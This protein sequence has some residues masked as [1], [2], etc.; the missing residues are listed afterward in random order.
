M[1]SVDTGKPAAAEGSALDPLRQP[2]FRTL[3]TATVVSN[4]GTWMQNAAAGWLMAGLTRD[5]FIVSLVPPSRPSA[6]S[7]STQPSPSTTTISSERQQ[8]SHLEIESGS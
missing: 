6:P 1:A 5:A 7:P 8:A 2:V 3:W 4:I